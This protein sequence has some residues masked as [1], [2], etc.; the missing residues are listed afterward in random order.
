M[1]PLPGLEIYFNFPIFP[2]ACAVGYK[3]PPAT[4]AEEKSFCPLS[5]DSLLLLT[6]LL[7]AGAILPTCR[8]IKDTEDLMA[9]ILIKGGR[10]LSPED[11][12]D[13]ALDV[14][15]EDGVIREI[16]PNLA[17]E[18]DETFDARGNVVAPGFIDIH[19][20]LRE[21]GGEASETLQT[22]LA[23][24]VAGMIVLVPEPW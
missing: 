15:I 12:L 8:I 24:A 23:A 22:G 14:R 4:R 11:N 21:P 17:G 1:S 16:G 2:T 7:N 10:V 20:H 13:G 19:V 5:F 6:A 18:A 3:M 9:S